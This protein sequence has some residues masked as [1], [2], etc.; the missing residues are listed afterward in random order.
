VDVGT[1]S[2]AIALVLARHLAQARVWATDVSLAAL[3][4]AR[5]NLQH[6]GLAQ[7]VALVCG[8][9]L[10]PLAGPFDLIAANLPYVT[11][12]ELPTLAPDVRAYEPRL[13]L[14]GGPDGLALIARLVDQAPERLARP[15]LL[16]LEIDPRQAAQVTALAHNAFPDA[17]VTIL[18]D[19]AGWDRVVCVERPM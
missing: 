16:L 11:S 9:L 6:Y 13:A 5:A 17:D 2:G 18:K 12:D 15:G 4:V 7:R 8:D 14:D 10:T 1:G 19:Y 3:H